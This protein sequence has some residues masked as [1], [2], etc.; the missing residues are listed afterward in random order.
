[1]INS[2]NVV[3]NEINIISSDT[4]EE[5][6]G[7]RNN[8]IHRTIAAEEMIFRK[9]SGF[10]TT[11]VKLITEGGLNFFHYLKSLG[12]SRERNLIVLSSK[13]HYYYDKN[14]LK[15]VRILINLR[16]LNL[17]KHLDLF[18]NSLCRTLPPD[19]GFIGYFSA[20]KTSKKNGFH[21]NWLPNLLLRLYKLLSSK[22][23]HFMDENEVSELL[24]EN[25]FKVVNM[26]KR[27]GLTYFY[28]HSNIHEQVKINILEA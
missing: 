27:N 28:S 5:S 22:T 23:E 10:S 17:I 26:T 21:L 3:K 2:L 11:N 19:A 8:K 12:L 6:T 15:T 14:E 25:G 24:E 1:M 13:H 7:V 20:N 16:K 9:Q 18:L 4:D